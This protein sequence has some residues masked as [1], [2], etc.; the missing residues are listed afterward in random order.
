MGLIVPGLI[1]H[2]I[3]VFNSK[4]I[5]SIFKQNISCLDGTVLLSTQITFVFLVGPML[6]DMD[7]ITATNP[8]PSSHIPVGLNFLFSNF[9]SKI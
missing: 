2:Q 5:F 7:F 8:A 4:L 1:C 3:K 6:C 9:K